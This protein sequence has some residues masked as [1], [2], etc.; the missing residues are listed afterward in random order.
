M[1]PPEP[2]PGA[3]RPSAL[4][5]RLLAAVARQVFGRRTAAT[6]ARA[7]ALW[8]RRA[9]AATKFNDGLEF[10]GT[11]LRRHLARWQNL[12]ANRAFSRWADAFRAG[13]SLD[14]LGDHAKRSL[15]TLL[16]LFSL[17]AP[18]DRSRRQTVRA[19]WD[20]LSRRRRPD[21]ASAR[22]RDDT[23][24]LLALRAQHDATLRRTATVW[25]VSRSRMTV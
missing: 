19:A 7:F 4:G 6:L 20:K 5:A 16:A 8:R 24:A 14:T 15:D 2:A 23:D 11:S 21:A 18:H 13:T 12:A 17:A 1:R 10:A 22:D 3:T 9:A 25:L